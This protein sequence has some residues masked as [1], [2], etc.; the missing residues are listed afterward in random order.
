MQNIIGLPTEN[1]YRRNGKVLVSKIAVDDTSLK[2]NILKAVD[3][4]G[5]FGK[6]I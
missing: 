3:L 5:G 4:I 6:I 1:L 2:E